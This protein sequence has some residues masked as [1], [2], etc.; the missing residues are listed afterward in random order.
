M[1]DASDRPGGGWPRRGGSRRYP[2]W[3]R[4]DRR[5]YRLRYNPRHERDVHATFV[6]PDAGGTLLLGR[7][8]IVAVPVVGGEPFYVIT[9]R[10]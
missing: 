5:D 2:R 6:L 8:Q 9:E 7:S 10:V 3:L 1:Q 4:A